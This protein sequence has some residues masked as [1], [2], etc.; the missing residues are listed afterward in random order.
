M[1]DKSRVVGSYRPG[2]ST[3]DHPPTRSRLAAGRALL[4]HRR[5][6]YVLLLGAV[7]IATGVALTITAELGVGSWQV[8]ETGLM[9]VSGAS[10][11]VVA[12]VESLVALAIAWAWLAQRPGPATVLFALAVGPLVGAFLGM[13]TPTTGAVAAAQL[14]AGMVVIGL[15]VGLYVGAGLGASA[16][17]SLFVGICSRFGMR[18]RDA[19][20]LT[21]VSLVTA[22]W[23]LG[24]Q[25]GIGT[26]A[27]TIG[28]P[29]VV[30]PGIRAGARLAGVAQVGPAAV[31]KGPAV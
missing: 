7:M 19:R 15:G 21:D 2:M 13:L 1:C 11:G 27:I 26:I 22:G 28:L 23:L 9:E 14:V 31:V 24:G 20:A 16:Q 5:Q 8:F 25:V 4:G 10:F 29:L 30:E 3:P 6:W 17:D 18:P 12:V